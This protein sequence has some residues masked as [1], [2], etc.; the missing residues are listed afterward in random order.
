VN[1]K[2]KERRFSDLSGATH[3]FRNKEIEIP[4]DGAYKTIDDFASA[5]LHESGH[6]DIWPVETVLLIAAMVG[7]FNIVAMHTDDPLK[8]LGIIGGE[9][10]VYNYMVGEIVVEGY[11]AVKHGAKKYLKL[12]WHK[13][14]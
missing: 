11:N 12:R 4:T 13:E 10:L 7:T 8:L 2:E 9:F 6:A 5:L 3:S 1:Y 14:K